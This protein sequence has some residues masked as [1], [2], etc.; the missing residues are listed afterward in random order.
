[1]TYHNDNDDLDDIP[2]TGPTNGRPGSQLSYAY[3][4]VIELESGGKFSMTFTTFDE[5]REPTV[6][7]ILPRIARQLQTLFDARQKNPQDAEAL[8]RMIADAHFVE[9]MLAG[10]NTRASRVSDESNPNDWV[11]VITYCATRIG[12]VTF[13][14]LQGMHLA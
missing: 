2:V 9:D 6:E 10:G 8:D 7:D 12:S 11:W 5:K 14:K 4:V 13:T 3:V 1:M